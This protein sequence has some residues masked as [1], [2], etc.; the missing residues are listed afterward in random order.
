MALSGSVYGSIGEKKNIR[1][2]FSDFDLEF[3][4]N[5]YSNDVNVYVNE[6]AITKS[7]K[8]LIMTHKGERKF[9]PDLGCNVYNMLFE[10]ITQFTA[11]N[12]K[13]SIEEVITNYETRVT[14]EDVIVNE[15]ADNNGYEITIVFYIMNQSTA[16]TFEYFLE[17]IR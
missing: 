17:R 9:Q 1:R 6:D 4:R 12:I 3:S 8:H 11:I 13:K 14:L 16:T 2:V 15:D 5:Q 7:I 10:N